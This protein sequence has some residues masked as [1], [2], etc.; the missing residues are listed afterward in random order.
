MDIDPYDLVLDSDKARA[1]DALGN[2]E[3]F[4]V[5][6]QIAKEH[7]SVAEYKVAIK[8][9]RNIERRFQQMLKLESK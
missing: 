5:D 8:L 4:L 2:A 1:I 7:L 6:S 9:L 3:D